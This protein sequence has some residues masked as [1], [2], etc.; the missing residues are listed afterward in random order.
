MYVDEDRGRN[1]DAETDRWGRGDAG[2]R[3]V[4]RFAV[5]RIPA[6]PGASR[7]IPMHLAWPETHF[8]DHGAGA[9]AAAIMCRHVVLAYI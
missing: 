5:A 4:P 6:H 7:R 3:D 1:R 8:A 2:E 9:A